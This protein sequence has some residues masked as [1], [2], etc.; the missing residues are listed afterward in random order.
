MTM[1]I[2]IADLYRRY[3]DTIEICTAAG[4]AAVRCVQYNGLVLDEI[5]SFQGDS[6]HYTFAIG[7]VE[8]L[9]VFVDDKVWSSDDNRMVT[10]LGIDPECRHNFI[11]AGITKGGFY[12][13]TKFSSCKLERQ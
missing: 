6:A 12:F 9:P 8:D 7:V 5:P 13:S 4:E 1:T 2:T 10:V 11:H 3:A